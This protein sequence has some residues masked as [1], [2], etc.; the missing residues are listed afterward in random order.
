MSHLVSSLGFN[1][2]SSTSVF[3]FC[4]LY[5]LAVVTI[6]W[7]VGLIYGNH[8]PMDAYYGFAYVIPAGF[9]YAIARPSSAIAAGLMVMVILHGCRLGWYL[10]ARMR[11]FIAAQGGDPRYLGFRQKYSPGYWWKSFFVVMEPQAILIALVG[12]PV[13]VG[14]LE[15]RHDRGPL[16]WLAFVGIAVFAVGL[17]F[18]SLADGQLQ[19]FLALEPRPRYLNTGVWKH[20]RHPNY[21]GTTTVWWGMWIVAVS[22]NSA[23][24]WTAIGPVINTLMLTVLTGTRMTDSIMGSRPHYRELMTRTRGFFPLPA[25]QPGAAPPHADDV[26]RVVDVD[27]RVAVDEQQIRLEPGRD[28][29]AVAEPEALGRDRGGSGQRL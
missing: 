2:A 9:A 17:Y 15:S 11:R 14:I 12:S 19:A 20:S 5:T 24:W 4:S 1:P 28:P 7:A 16:G 27:R 29:A 25:R 26:E 3:L 13:V 10:A 8:S 6:F 23:V 18:E 21:F 22:G